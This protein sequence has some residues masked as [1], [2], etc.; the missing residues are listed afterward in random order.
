MSSTTGTIQVWGGGGSTPPSL[1]KVT[2]IPRQYQVSGP[3]GD[4]CLSGDWDGE[5]EGALPDASISFRPFWPLGDVGVWPSIWRLV[6]DIWPSKSLDLVAID[7]PVV[8]MNWNSRWIS[9]HNLGARALTRNKETTGFVLTTSYPW[10]LGVSLYTTNGLPSRLGDTSDLGKGSHWPSWTTR[11]GNLR[12]GHDLPQLLLFN[13]TFRIL[14]LHFE[15]TQGCQKCD[16]C[17]GT[18]GGLVGSPKQQ[19][20]PHAPIHS[21]RLWSMPLQYRVQE[22]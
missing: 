9:S 16:R 17:S 4:G 13:Q 2:C 7:T 18:L 22:I 21:K 12:D 10:W 15:P 8:V 1:V 5:W 19:F 14:P 3:P 11:Y 6:P 20:I